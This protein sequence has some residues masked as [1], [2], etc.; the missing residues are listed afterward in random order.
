MVA[1]N[2]G[3]SERMEY[4]V[5]GKA[6]NLSIRLRDMAHNLDTDILINAAAYDAVRGVYRADRLPVELTNSM[7][8]DSA[9]YRMD[10]RNAILENVDPSASSSG[11]ET[12]AS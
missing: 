6:A 9:V 8:L 5:V 7:N 3:S 12:N 11:S 2:I 10:H 1:G 4:T